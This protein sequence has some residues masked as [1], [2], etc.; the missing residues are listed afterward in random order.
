MM[1]AS[2]GDFGEAGITVQTL[3]S[4]LRYLALKSVA[5]KGTRNLVCHGSCLFGDRPQN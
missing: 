1:A 5:E 4:Q 3:P 2:Q